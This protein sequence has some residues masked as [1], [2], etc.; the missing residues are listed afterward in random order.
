MAISRLCIF[1]PDR[2]DLERVSM[3]KHSLM[4]NVLQHRNSL[5]LALALG[6][7]LA[8]AGPAFGQATTGS[9]FG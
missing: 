7:G 6:L 2:N 8:A 4:R 3:N 9:I 1:T 5:T